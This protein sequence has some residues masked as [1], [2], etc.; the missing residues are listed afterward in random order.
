[1]WQINKKDP[2]VILIIQHLQQP[3]VSHRGSPMMISMHQKLGKMW[4]FF[5]IKKPLWIFLCFQS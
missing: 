1:V 3:I 4:G 2:S 5:M